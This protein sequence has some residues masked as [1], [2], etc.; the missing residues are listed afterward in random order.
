VLWLMGGKKQPAKLA[1]SGKGCSPGRRE[2]PAA[3]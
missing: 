1:E 3:K 2:T